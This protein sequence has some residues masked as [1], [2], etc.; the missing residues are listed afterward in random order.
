MGLDH[1][2][3][4]LGP[5]HL[6]EDREH[7]LEARR[8]RS[9]Y[10]RAALDVEQAR[11][12]SI[13]LAFVPGASGV[14]PAARTSVVVELLTAATRTASLAR[15]AWAICDG[16]VT[17]PQLGTAV[18]QALLQASQHGVGVRC[19]RISALYDECCAAG[20]ERCDDCCCIAAPL[21]FLVL[22]L[23]QC[24]FCPWASCSYSSWP[25]GL[26]QCDK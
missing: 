25:F 17:T 6:L 1:R 18:S 24:R 12:R 13:A 21:R 7:G 10:F 23:L 16:A 5:G 4:R 8:R 11:A 20:D 22:H 15:S 3:A 14:S 9:S 26:Q 19:V 2:L